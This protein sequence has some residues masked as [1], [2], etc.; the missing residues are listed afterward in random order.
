MLAFDRLRF[1]DGKKCRHE[2]SECCIY[3]MKSARLKIPG[4]DWNFTENSLRLLLN[5]KLDYR[6]RRV[7]EVINY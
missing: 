3:E 4:R 1:I 5:I 2:F 7:S 6:F